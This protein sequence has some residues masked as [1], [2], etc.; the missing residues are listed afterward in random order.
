[1]GI[2]EK[3]IFDSP[4]GKIMRSRTDDLTDLE[5]L[6]YLRDAILKLAHRRKA[7][8]IRVFGSL[9]KGTAGEASDIDFL[10]SMDLDATLVDLI[11]LEQDLEE[12]LGRDV[13]VLTEDAI[14]PRLREDI[15]S[16]V[17]RL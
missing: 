6:R 1:V 13:D 10:V 3:S 4:A 14:H 15:R 16:T 8:N 5:D 12:L 2:R 7:R 9:A 17:I 11:G